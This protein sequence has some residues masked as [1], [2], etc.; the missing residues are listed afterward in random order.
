MDPTRITELAAEIQENMAKVD[1]YFQRN[2]LPTPSFGEDGPVDFQIGS[3]EIQTAREK[4]IDSSLEL[5]Q[6]LLGPALL[7]RPVVRFHVGTTSYCLPLVQCQKWHRYHRGRW[8]FTRHLQRC[9][10]SLVPRL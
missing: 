10:G 3:G 9:I 1:Q 6:L 2:G 5:H 7:L 8:R 4:A